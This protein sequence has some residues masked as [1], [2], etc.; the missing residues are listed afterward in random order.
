MG[1][2]IIVRKG[3]IVKKSA[4]TLYLSGVYVPGA[5]SVKHFSGGIDNE[6]NLDVIIR[7]QGRII[8][9]GEQC[10]I[11][12]NSCSLSKYSQQIHLPPGEYVIDLGQLRLW[13]NLSMDL[14]ISLVPVNDGLT[15]VGAKPGYVNMKTAKGSTRSYS[16]MISEPVRANDICVQ[17]FWLWFF[18]PITDEE[19]EVVVQLTRDNELVYSLATTLFRTGMYS[20][21][22]VDALSS[23]GGKIEFL[24]PLNSFGPL[25]VAQVR[26]CGDVS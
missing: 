23:L 25:F 10:I 17:R 26:G 12:L 4:S 15:L 1:T 9:R 6:L 5:I 22:V 14:C 13:P 19:E 7:S 21:I 3:I 11:S 24:S 16:L 20:E 8:W 2:R 18:R